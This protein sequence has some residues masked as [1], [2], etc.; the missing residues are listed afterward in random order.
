MDVLRGIFFVIIC[1]FLS[2]IY[3]SFF[4]LVNDT[5]FPEYKT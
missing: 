5:V 1:L 2:S 3:T 4:P